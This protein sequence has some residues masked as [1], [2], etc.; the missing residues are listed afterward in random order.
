M[1][2]CAGRIG[3]QLNLTDIATNCSISVPTAN[4]WL[5]ILEAGYI[6]YIIQP[7]HKN[8]NKRLTKSP[9]LYFYDTGL[10]CSLL[11]I[12]SPSI[13][14][15]SPFRGHIFENLIIGDLCKQYFNQGKRPPL[16]FWREQNGRIEIDCIIDQATKLNAIEIKSSE[17]TTSAFLDALAEWNELSKT[18]P[19]DNY[20][21]YA[22][23]YNQK[24]SRGNVMSWQSIGTLITTLEEK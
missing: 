2:L 22:G 5:S 15:V 17:T 6:L 12:T 16:Y 1:A 14:S 23:K 13:I 19:E 7:Y 20:L 10:A 9:K 8:Y 3:Q 24:R 4:K 21:I 11:G 18:N